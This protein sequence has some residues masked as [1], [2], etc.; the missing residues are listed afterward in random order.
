[1]LEAHRCAQD[2]PDHTQIRA[3]PK[4][5]IP[6][7]RTPAARH[8]FETPAQVRMTMEAVNPFRP[9]GLTAFTEVTDRLRWA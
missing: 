5:A 3:A 8:D 7:A 6:R 4:G 9:A 2:L 1:M